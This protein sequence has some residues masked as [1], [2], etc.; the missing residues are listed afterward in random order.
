[1][2]YNDHMAHDKTTVMLMDIILF[3][4]VK[5]QVRQ[6][7]GKDAM[8]GHHPSC[9]T[10]TCSQDGCSNVSENWLCLT[11]KKIFCGRWAK[12]HMVQHRESHGHA[13]AMGLSDLSFWCYECDAYLDVASFP[14][15]HPIYSA[16]HKLKFGTSPPGMPSSVGSVGGGGSTAHSDPERIMEFQE[17][18]ED[19]TT[20][21]DLLAKW[22]A[23]AKHMVVFTGAGISTSAG[24]PDFR[25]PEG[26]WTLKAQ[27]RARTGSTTS[28]LK[29]FPTVT[30]MSLV[31][32]QDSGRLKY[33]I[34]QNC[35]GL[36]KRSGIQPDHISELH[37]NGNIELC[38]DCGQEYFRD[39]QA[40]RKYRGRDH[41]TGRHCVKP[42]ATG[43]QGVCN[44]RLLESTVDF[45][46]NLPERP[47]ELADQ[48]SHKA[49]LHI[50]LGSS[51]TVQPACL[52]PRITAQKGGRLV[53]VNLQKTDLDRLCALRIFAKTDQV[54][55]M[56]MAK[57][58]MQIPRWQLKRELIVYHRYNP[59]GV[60]SSFSSS[61]PTSSVKNR[62]RGL[63]GIGESAVKAPSHTISVHGVDPANAKLPYS[64]C[65]QVGYRWTQHDG[66][67][68]QA[69]ISRSPFSSEL[70]DIDFST[71]PSTSEITDKMV[72][73]L[74]NKDD[75]KRQ[76]N[77]QQKSNL[78]YSVAEVGINFRG[79]YNEPSMFL[80]V[81]VL[82][83]K[84][85]AMRYTLSWTPSLSAS[86]EAQGR[87]LLWKMESAVPVTP[88]EH[89]QWTPLMHSLLGSPLPSLK[90]TAKRKPEQASSREGS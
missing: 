48:H 82:E 27:G 73:P 59:G 86:V 72:I 7:V 85:N 16:Y 52:M 54:M 15:L 51:L 77:G 2:Y 23:E 61:S 22:I 20:K 83:G 63:L 35:D 79:H 18:R 11:C 57:L 49:D 62:F 45:G 9:F 39:Y 1:M 50:V 68:A 36:H 44:G 37:G 26:V 10:A 47:L 32:L 29:A 13:I 24:I 89:G 34:S 40:Y 5:T 70:Q 58:K 65:S 90:A 60:S 21:T 76:H 43:P 28:T 78:K 31:A 71:K 14:T 66:R 55:S 12:R 30:H 46:Q 80:Q 19:L 42:K 74:G 33:L 3:A 87:V 56:V 53:I 69:I 41:Y 88:E 84:D 6:H 81:P 25:G 17:T 4:T 8:T 75:P 64:V 67:R 38:E